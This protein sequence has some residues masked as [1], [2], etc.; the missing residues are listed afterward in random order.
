M[1]QLPGE[2]IKITVPGPYPQRYLGGESQV[3]V[4][5]KS[6]QAILNVQPELRT[7]SHDWEK[8]PSTASP[9]K[10]DRLKTHGFSC[11]QRVSFHGDEQIVWFPD[12]LSPNFPTPLPT[13]VSTGMS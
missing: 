2:L 1:S 7:M 8:N 4:D 10:G 13:S 6:P 9:G 11:L 12:L 5:F 3:G